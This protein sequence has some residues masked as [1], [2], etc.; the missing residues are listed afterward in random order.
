MPM[1]TTQ[2]DLSPADTKALTAFLASEDRPAGTLSFHEL[3][4]FLFTIASAPE[5]I[6]P[7]EWLPL[8]SNEDEMGYASLD[9]AQ[10]TLERLMAL[11]NEINAGVLQRNDS[12]PAG[13]AFHEDILANLDEAATISQWSRGF[14][15]GHGGSRNCGMNTYLMH[16]MKNAAPPS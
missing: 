9:E 1:R 5:T 2:K 3:Q 11:Y 8:I 6:A 10:Q 12:L 7:S 14:M 13:C 16:W 15:L 4:G